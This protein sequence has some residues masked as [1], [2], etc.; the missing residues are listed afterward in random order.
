MGIG[1]PEFVDNPENRCPVLLICDT[2]QAMDK[3]AIA[4][5]N[6]ALIDF[7]YDIE[8][9]MVASLRVE[10]GLVTFGRNV[11][12]VQEFTNIENFSPPILE[13]EGYIHIGDAL[14]TGLARV[15][16]RKKLYKEN[17]IPYYR[18]WVVLI[19]D[20]IVE[21]FSPLEES[22]NEL[23][24]AEENNKITFFAITVSG[25]NMETLKRISPPNRPLLSLQGIDFRNLFLWLSSSISRISASIVGE[26]KEEDNNKLAKAS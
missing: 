26:N 18:P 9:D 16:Q 3:E 22:I 17:G 1:L 11:Q 10:V 4:T 5:I 7:K 21:D 14:K 25:H 2:S 23:H 12:V 13:S 15:E 24:A 20:T 19:T 8:Q 6:K